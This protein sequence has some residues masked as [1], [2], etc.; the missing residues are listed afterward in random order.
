MDHFCNRARN[1]ETCA[2]LIYKSASVYNQ[3]FCCGKLWLEAEKLTQPR[4]TA[5]PMKSSFCSTKWIRLYVPLLI[6]LFYQFYISSHDLIPYPWVYQRIPWKSG[7]VTFGGLNSFSL[8]AP[9]YLNAT[10]MQ[11][12]CQTKQTVRF[13]KITRM[14]DEKHLL[15]AEL[16]IK[17]HEMHNCTAIP[18]VKKMSLALFGSI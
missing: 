18:T 14:R 13:Y 5:W 7:S 8:W 2:M 9:I 16:R 11:L 15:K 1:P 17:N 4:G 3:R 12:N 6:Y 10:H